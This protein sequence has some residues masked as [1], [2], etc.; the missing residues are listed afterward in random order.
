[1]FKKVLGFTAATLL[2]AGCSDLATTSD[3]FVAGESSRAASA[4][5]HYVKIA[6]ASTSN[7]EQQTKFQFKIT[8]LNIQVNDAISFTVQAPSGAK[9]LTVRGATTD[10]KYLSSYS[11]SGGTWYNISTT[12]KSA[13][14]ELGITFYTS[15][16]KTS[17][18]VIIGDLK[19]GSKWISAAD[20]KNATKPYYSSPA[21]LS[22]SGSNTGSSDSGNN[23]GN[24]GSSSNLPVKTGAHEQFSVSVNELSG[25]E[26]SITNDFFWGVDDNGGVYKVYSNGSRESFWKK[27]SAMT[28]D[29]MEGVAMD[30]ATGDLYIGLESKDYCLAVIPNK[31]TLESPSYSKSNAKFFKAFG[32]DWGNSGVEGI[33]WYKN[34]QL[35]IGTQQKNAPLFLCKKDGTVISSKKLH[36]VKASN[37]E[38]NDITEVAGLDYDPENDWLW[39]VDS[40]TFKIYLF[41]GNIMSD[42][43]RLLKTYKI[44]DY[45]KSNPEGICVDSKKGYIWIS[46]DKETTSILHRYTFTGLKK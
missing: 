27:D 10:N 22:F 44:N 39:V 4:P 16:S 6:A 18:A 3:E 45:A 43:A 37:G 31:G 19:I 11:V 40:N 17:G 25:I 34:N 9:S 20:V 35:Y 23:G 46:E 2:L 33:T 21:S 29:E 5:N 13:D 36:D 24:G 7:W 42:S 28:C 15:N 14:S 30:P 32:S 38:T 26:L 8:G 12:A 41:T 1:M